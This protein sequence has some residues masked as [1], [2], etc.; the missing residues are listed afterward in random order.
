MYKRKKQKTRIKIVVLSVI[1]VCLVISSILVRKNLNLPSFFLKDSIL[2]IDSFFGNFFGSFN[3]KDYDDLL[4]ENENLKKEL[5]L[6]KIYKNENEELENQ[7]LKLKEVIN[8]N[9]ALSDN[10]YINGSVINRDFDYFQEKLVIDVGI[11]DGVSGNMAVVSDGGLV[12]IT[13]DVSRSNSSVLLLCN[14]GFPINISVKIKIDSGYVY[15]I[16]NNYDS[17]TGYFEVV[18]VVENVIIPA[19]SM[20]VTTGLG[21]IF[22]SGILVGYVDD[23]TTDNFDLSKIV[24]VKSSV[25]FDDISYVTVVKRDDK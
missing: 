2:A 15:G 13:D 5:E 14:K 22:P 23:I 1:I 17:N 8:V 6:Y 3:N 9:S 12:G 10:S 21:S 4:M 16:L 20:V 11:N 7:I 19:G 25:D 18:G 24:N